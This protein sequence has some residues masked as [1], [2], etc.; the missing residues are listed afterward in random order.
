MK[1]SLLKYSL[2]LLFFLGAC[3]TEKNT[4]MTRTYHNITSHYNIYFNGYES[5]KRGLKKIEDNYD[6]NYSRLLPVFYYSDPDVVQTVAPDMDRALEKATKVI[7]LHSITAKPDLKRGAQTEK[8]KEFYNKKEYNKWIDDNYI[9]MGKAYIYKNEFRTA[10][11]TLRKMI[12]DFPNEETRF[13]AMIW[14]IRGL[15]ELEEYREAENLLV[16]LSSQD[17]LP[18]EYL[19]DLFITYADHFI[20]QEKYEQAIPHLKKALSLIRK[21]HYKIRYTYILAQLYQETGQSDNTVKTYRKVIRMNPPYEM[22]FNA[23]INMASSFEAGSGEGKEIRS[24]LEKMLKDDKNIDYQDQIYF[25]LGNI[26]M[27]EKKEADAID[28]YQMS[29]LT[30]INNYNQKGLSYV[31]LGDIYYKRPDYIISQAYYDSSLQNIDQEYEDFEQLSRK[32]QSLN[33]LVEHYSVYTLEDSVQRLAQLPEKELFLVIDGI[34][35]EVVKKEEEEKRRQQ[36]EMLDMQYGMAMGNNSSRNTGNPEGGQWYFYNMNAKSFGQPEFRMKWGNRKLEDNWR[37]KNKQ[38]IDII[39][40]PEEGEI[41]DS[42]ATETT[43]VLSN[44]NREFYLKDIP[45]SDSAFQESNEKLKVALYNMGLVYR[46]ELRDIDEAVNSFKEVTERFPND[47]YALLSAYNLYEIYNLSGNNSQRDFYKNWI[48][49][50][51][52][53]SPRAK[54]LADPDYVNQLLQEQNR[55]NRFYEET[56]NKFNSGDNLGVIRNVEYAMGEFN[57]HKIIPKFELLGAIAQGRA[58]GDTIMTRELEKIVEKY[59]GTEESQFARGIMDALYRESPELEVADTREKAA[60]IYNVDTT[61]VF[62]FGIAAKSAVDINQLKFNLINFNLDNFE[63]LNISIQEE[64]IG[65]M[66]YVFVKLF[67]DYTMAQ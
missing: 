53:D 10:I 32:A 46:N 7:T 50:N 67:E 15:N 64:K 45:L 48:I 1:K 57:G 31:A 9:L 29:A 4:L 21:K 11:E 26:A 61:G 12:L 38:S 5:F 34:I 16:A 42:V 62:F 37:R 27:K 47:E 20:K 49:R 41:I 25:A 51:F 43:R 3:S 30:S 44:K 8:Q 33:H 55:V 52:P 63:R 13:E 58:G 18:K 59:P 28:N 66:N 24:L 35:E 22:T 39:E 56:Y 40:Q 2:V 14:L 60:E 19:S 6:E 65:D 17:D 36:E 23:K 54:I